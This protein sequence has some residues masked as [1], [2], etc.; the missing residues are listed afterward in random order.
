MPTCTMVHG[1][2]QSLGNNSLTLPNHHEWG[3]N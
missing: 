1:I 3:K 2:M